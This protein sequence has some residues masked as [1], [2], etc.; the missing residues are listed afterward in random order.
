MS[1]EETIKPEETGVAKINGPTPDAWQ[2]RQDR[3]E[4]LQHAVNRQRSFGG[5]MTNAPTAEAIVKEA[6]QFLDFLEGKDK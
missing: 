5:M 3:G 4:A 2:K 1:N 6:E